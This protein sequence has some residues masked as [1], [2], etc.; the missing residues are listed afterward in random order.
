MIFE[1]VADGGRVFFDNAINVDVINE[2]D[3]AA[4]V[5]I[6]SVLIKDGNVDGVTVDTHAHDGTGT[7]APQVAA[8]NTT[9]APATLGDWDSSADPGDTDDALDQLAARVKALEP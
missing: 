6:D 2:R 9:Y 3:S 7:G 1:R 4:G 8:T 5:T